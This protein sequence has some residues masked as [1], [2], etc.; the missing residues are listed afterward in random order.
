MSSNYTVA[1]SDNEIIEKVFDKNFDLK[2]I[3][4][5]E[6]PPIQIQKLEENIVEPKIIKY[7]PNQAT[8]STNQ[9]NNSLLFLSDAYDTDWH[10]YID[11]KKSKILRADYA[12][13]A[14][15]VPAGE[16]TVDFKYQPKS[17]VMGALIS[18]SSILFLIVL[19]IYF[20]K[21]KQF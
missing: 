8:F 21:K 17:F 18:M 7:E 1:Q 16:H 5:E 3:V 11:G 6:Q 4:L 10:S 20:V 2:T 13:R 19:S 9:K 15:A 12:L 14:V